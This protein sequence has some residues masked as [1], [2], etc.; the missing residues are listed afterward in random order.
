MYSSATALVNNPDISL[1][2]ANHS[3]VL[4]T[5]LS[6]AT[7]QSVRLFKL[8]FYNVLLLFINNFIYLLKLLILSK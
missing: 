2:N 8:L 1:L 5:V 7:K 3:A 4:P 6:E